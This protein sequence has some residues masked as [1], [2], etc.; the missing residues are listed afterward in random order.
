MQMIIKF[1]HDYYPQF[2]QFSRILKWLSSRKDGKKGFVHEMMVELGVP[3]AHLNSCITFMIG[4]E[5]LT[6]RKLTLTDFGKTVMNFDPFFERLETLW[7]I[8][9]LISSN[10]ELIIWHRV[11][12]NIL[13]LSEQ[14]F[15]PSLKDLY[16][17]D[18]KS[19]VS[20]H[21]YSNKI[22]GEIRAVFYAYTKS[23]LSRLRIITVDEQGNFIKSEPVGVP[24]LAFCYCLLRFAEKTFPGSTAISIAEI[25]QA[26]NGPAKVLFLTEEQV[27]SNLEELHH[28][29]LVRL[30][31]LANL[32][33][34][35]F[36]ETVTPE[37]VLQKIYERPDGN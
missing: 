10:P 5:L 35:R 34:V 26:E 16:F 25:C 12:H 27:R 33:Q 23:A 11:I 18:L 28:S 24:P 19:I 31:R 13:P 2:E 29:G 8:H 9:Y 7:I 14:Y 32:D 36:L 20:K 22:P 4:C 6:A 30:E 37:L 3:E 21:T 15:L 17:Y 1:T